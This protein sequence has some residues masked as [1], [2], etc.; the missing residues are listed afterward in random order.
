M[1]VND[2]SLLGA[3]IIIAIGLTYFA[4]RWVLQTLESDRRIEGPDGLWWVRLHWSHPRLSLGVA[5]KVFKLK[6]DDLREKFPHHGQARKRRKSKESS[7][8]MDALAELGGCFGDAPIVGVAIVGALLLVLAIGLAL[9][10]A[11]FV[12]GA[13]FVTV[14]R[15]S[16]GHPWSIEV[17]EPEGTVHLLEVRGWQNART[18]AAI[19]RESIEAGEFDIQAIE[20]LAHT[21]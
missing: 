21:T 15:T 10:L 3:A 5:R 12:I 13:A 16:F 9:E 2:A 1:T 11:V 18:A 6:S 7:Y 8:S 4:V 19:T 17:D 20:E 14:L